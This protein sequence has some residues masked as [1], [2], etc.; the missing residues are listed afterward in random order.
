MT[1]SNRGVVY[2]G[3][4]HVEVQSIAF[5][6]LVAPSGTTPYVDRE[7]LADE[8]VFL[9][10]EDEHALRQEMIVTDRVSRS[11][12]AG[13]SAYSDFAFSRALMHSA[14]PV[15][16]TCAGRFGE[17]RLN[18][19]PCPQQKSAVHA[20]KVEHVSIEKDSDRSQ[21]ARR[22][23]FNCIQLHPCYCILDCLTRS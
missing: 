8:T 7:A 18:G 17:F 22:S 21:E 15:P 13:V 1:A 11:Q 5:P 2:L 6:K 9:N 4:G 3:Q 19:K 10:L 14:E 23:C 16:E 20:L 12:I